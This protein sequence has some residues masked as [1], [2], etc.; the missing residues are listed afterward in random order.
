MRKILFLM[1]TV[2]TV[3]GCKSR[4]EKAADLIK[5]DMFKILYDFESYEPIETKIDSAFTSIYT[6]T[7]ALMYANDIKIIFDELEEEKGEYENAKSS[8]QIWSDSYSSLGIYKYNE[9][10]NTVNNYLEKINNGLKKIH[11]TYAKIKERNDH[12]DRSFIGWEA[13]HKFRCKTKGGNFDL[14]NYIY[15]FD[16]SMKKISYSRDAD[17]K[18]NSRLIGIIGAA[19][20]SDKTEADIDGNT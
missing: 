6:D 1:M 18:E 8:M 9:A 5:Q 3:V 19:I 15:I 12:M 17:D 10:K 20:Q 4:E 14:G 7:L 2:F 13:E 16:K 11:D